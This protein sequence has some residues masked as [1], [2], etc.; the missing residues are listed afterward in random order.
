MSLNWHL[1]ESGKLPP[2]EIMDKDADLLNQL[3]ENPRPILHFYEWSTPCLTYGYFT[4]PSLFLDL[5]SLNHYG[6]HTAKRPT[7]GGIIFHLTDFA[8]SVLIPA[9]HP[10]FSLNT[11]DNYAFI[12]RK[13]AKAITFLTPQ[14]ET[15]TLFNEEGHECEGGACHGFCMA[16]PTQFDLMLGGK[17]VGGAAQRRTRHGFLHQGSISLFFPPKKMLLKI[18]KNNVMILDAMHLHSYCLLPSR[19]NFKELNDM[20]EMIKKNLKINFIE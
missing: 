3:E 18:L 5:E 9:N 20:R 1:I 19:S 2:Q 6:L 15:P 14:H 7:G 17:K 8:F 13:I 11:L 4:N 16:Q 12:N 10:N